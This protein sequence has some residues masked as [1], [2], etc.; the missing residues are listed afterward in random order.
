MTLSEAFKKRNMPHA[1]GGETPLESLQRIMDTLP[2]SMAE[3]GPLPN[4]V[5]A[6]V[7]ANAYY[8][9]LL[10]LGVE[11]RRRI[12]ESSTGRSIQHELSHVDA[13]L[14]SYDVNDP[15]LDQRD[16]RWVPLRE[17]LRTVLIDLM[18]GTGL[19]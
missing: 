18:F 2:R 17:A 13:T 12:E 8:R 4:F 9:T 16:E 3:D 14:I 10:L 7:F 6:L 15:V 19:D 1:S 5:D 11:S